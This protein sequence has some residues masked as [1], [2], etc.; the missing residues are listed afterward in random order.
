MASSSVQERS[1]VITPVP[2][3]IVEFEKV[4]MKPNNFL[5]LLNIPKGKEYYLQRL[6]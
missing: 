3:F 1:G 6:P 5:P 2:H 4:E